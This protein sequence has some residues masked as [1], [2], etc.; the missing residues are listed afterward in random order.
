MGLEVINFNG[1]KPKLH[2]I[3]IRNIFRI[4]DV[5]LYFGSIPAF[6]SKKQRRLGDIVA[7]TRVVE[8][9]DSSLKE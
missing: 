2:Q 1:L 9:R 3:I 8:I 5:F 4:T 7:K 6:L